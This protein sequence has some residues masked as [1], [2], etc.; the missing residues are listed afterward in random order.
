LIGDLCCVQTREREAAGGASGAG[1]L[2]GDDEELD[3]LQV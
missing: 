1:V 3:L 2:R